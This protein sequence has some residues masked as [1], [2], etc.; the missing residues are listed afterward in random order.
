VYAWSGSAA[1]TLTAD[2]AE[3]AFTGAENRDGLADDATAHASIGDLDGDGLDELALGDAD[4][5]VGTVSA[6]GLVYVVYG[7]VVTP[8]VYDVSAASS[9]QVYGTVRSTGFGMAIADA[10]DTNADGY[11]DLVVGAPYASRDGGAVYV[12]EGPISGSVA[13]DTYAALWTGARGE[14]AGTNLSAGDLDGDGWSELLVSATGHRSDTLS[15][16]GGAYVV[17]GGSVGTNLLADAFTVIEGDARNETAGQ[18]ISF[19]QDWD[20]DGRDEVAVGSSNASAS[21][22]TRNGETAVFTGGA[23]YP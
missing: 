10:A 8:G 3:Y 2:T 19:V 16:V 4:Q 12:F 5:R 23:L 20:G 9:A 18:A 21:G 11:G 1:G 6:A 22:L 14:N 13:A 17:L 15:D 7:G